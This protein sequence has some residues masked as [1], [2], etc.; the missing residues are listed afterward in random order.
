MNM[1]G[2]NFI[3]DLEFGRL[4]AC[5]PFSLQQ[6]FMFNFTGSHY[7]GLLTQGV[8]QEVGEFRV[9]IGCML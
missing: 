9:A 7:R 5:S 8:L 1:Q 3:Q 2:S 4:E 6:L